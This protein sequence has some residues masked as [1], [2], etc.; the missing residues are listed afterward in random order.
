MI[1]SHVIGCSK[2]CRKRRAE[3]LSP[4]AAP[5]ADVVSIMAV[6]ALVGDLGSLAKPDWASEAASAT[7]SWPYW[8]DPNENSPDSEASKRA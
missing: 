2:L 8:L 3:L 7:P 5:P 1:V 6:W 4:I